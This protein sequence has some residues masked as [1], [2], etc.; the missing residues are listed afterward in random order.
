[1]KNVSSDFLYLLARHDE[2]PICV[3]HKVTTILQIRE[4]YSGQKE[5]C[6]NIQL[7][8]CGFRVNPLPLHPKDKTSSMNTTAD[9][10]FITASATK[11]D[12]IKMEQNTRDWTE[13]S[14]L[15]VAAM[16]RRMEELGMTQQVLAERMNCTQQ[17]ISKM[18]KGGKNMSL[19]TI[20]KIE[21]ALGIE[22]IK[23]LDKYGQ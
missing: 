5:D 21:N 11:T 15:I 23:G 18:L 3:Q 20:C 8:S 17:H 14:R 4:P 10:K 16:S 12:E 7:F 19:E 1:M 13:Y 2:E 9:K 22:I 6:L